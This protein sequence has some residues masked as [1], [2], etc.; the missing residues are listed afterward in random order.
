MQPPSLPAQLRH[1][2]QRVADGLHVHA[3]LA[4]HEDPPGVTEQPAQG[5]PPG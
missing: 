3:E 5:A 1:G 4:D 2:V